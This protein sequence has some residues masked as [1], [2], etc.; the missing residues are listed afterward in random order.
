MR[1]FWDQR[2]DTE[3]FVYGKA[4]NLFFASHLQR[5][6]PARILL[7]GEGEGR[8]AVYAAQL[9]WEVHAFDQ[10]SV[11]SE[12][13]R[14]FAREQG[15]AIDYQVAELEQYTFRQNHYDAVGLI[16]FHALP[17]VRTLLHTQA[18]AALKPHGVLILE[19]FH[20]S[21]LGKGTGGPQSREMLFDQED[22]LVD[23]SALETLC[24]ETLS[25]PLDEGTYHR[26]EARVIRYLGKKFKS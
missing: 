5:F 19:A 18:C 23:F 20:T 3:D 17:S 2:Y 22:L 11:G 10:S 13:A 15:V 1:T 7:P 9:G 16:F 12:K 6:P 4:P 25:V 14:A 8:N 26:G 24:I 21:Q